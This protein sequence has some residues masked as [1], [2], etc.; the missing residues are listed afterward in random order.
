M[1]TGHFR[2]A[3]GWVVE[4]DLPLTKL[5]QEQADRGRL[6]PVVQAANGDWLAVPEDER[7]A[8][9]GGP[10]TG[11]ESGQEGQRSGPVTK[12]SKA[13]AGSGVENWRA[14]ALSV[15]EGLTDEAAAEMTRSDL[16]EKYGDA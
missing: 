7:A 11:P 8:F 4:L 3:G 6:I 16:I 13:G 15:D 10:E 12:P 1:D 5:M 2:T 9:L 14:Y